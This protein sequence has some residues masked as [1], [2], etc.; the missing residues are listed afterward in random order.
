[1]LLLVN[2]WVVLWKLQIVQFSEK[3]S[4]MSKQQFVSSL[5]TTYSIWLCFCLWVL[6][7]LWYLIWSCVAL[8]GIQS[9]TCLRRKGLKT[10][11]SRKMSN[12]RMRSSLRIDTILVTMAMLTIKEILTSYLSL[13]KVKMFPSKPIKWSFPLPNPTT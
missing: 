1:M 4:L 2:L 12:Y 6:G 13:N 11:S 10:L 3:F 7:W 9:C 5:T 8:W